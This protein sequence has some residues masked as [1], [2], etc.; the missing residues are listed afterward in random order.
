MAKFRRVP[1]DYHLKKE[2][3]SPGLKTGGTSAATKA[4]RAASKAGG[5][6]GLGYG[7]A[8]A[9]AQA[10][11]RRTGGT[12]TPPTI[13]GMPGGTGTGG[14]HY[15]DRQR[16]KEF[17]GGKYGGGDRSP[18]F[19]GGRDSQVPVPGVQPGGYNDPAIQDAM[20]AV[21]E[22]KQ[23]QEASKQSALG[24]FQPIQQ[25][26]AGM[27]PELISSAQM[28]KM[29]TTRR[30]EL[31][32]YGQ[33]LASMHT[34]PYSGVQGAQRRQIGMGIAGRQANM[35]IE[36]ELGVGAANRQAQL[37]LYGAQAGVAGQMSQIQ[38]AYQYD[39][40][41]EYLKELGYGAGYQ[42]ASS[43]TGGA[44]PGAGIVNEGPVRNRRLLSSDLGPAKKR[45]TPTF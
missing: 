44:T 38:Q 8:Q 15:Y 23:K 9:K 29:K 16:E 7:A 6:T 26:L 13:S 27:S 11:A 24:Y 3:S 43:G 32:A 1:H 5:S 14:Q 36:L 20:K 12:Y 31:G 41:M 45:P 4:K 18:E 17:L 25:S 2:I 19:P 42:G 35:P 10:E 30:A 33:N 40:G 39:P 37:G 28:A 22:A 21:E 34:D